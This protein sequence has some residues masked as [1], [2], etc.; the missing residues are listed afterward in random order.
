MKPRLVSER[1]LQEIVKF[2]LVSFSKGTYHEVLGI[3]VVDM[4]DDI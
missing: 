3:F 1:P 4:M 2:M